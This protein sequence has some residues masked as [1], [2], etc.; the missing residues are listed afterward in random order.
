MELGSTPTDYQRVGTDEMTVMAGVRKLSDAADG[1]LVELTTNWNTS[2]TN[3]GGFYLWVPE[4]SATPDLAV[5]SGARGTQT[6]N[7]NQR[8]SALL[9][10][11]PLQQTLV[12]SSSHDISGDLT[13][14]RVNA[15]AESNA[16][17]EK[18][19]GNFANAAIYLMRRGGTTNPLSGILYSL[20]VRGT[21]TPTGT[22][23]DFEKLLA[24]RAGVTF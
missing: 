19:G 4:V 20:I 11:Y 18:G 2:P 22:V 8:T 15:T 12:I 7:T 13:T 1:N 16:T 23:R 24:K 9:T 17:G 5:A 14:L 21:Q 6:V 3:N 10:S